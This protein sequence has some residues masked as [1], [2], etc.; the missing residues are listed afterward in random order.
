[1]WGSQLNKGFVS[2]VRPFWNPLWLS[3]SGVEIRLPDFVVPQAPMWHHQP[4]SFGKILAGGFSPPHRYRHSHRRPTRRHHPSQRFI[5]VPEASPANTSNSRHSP[6]TKQ[7]SAAQNTGKRVEKTS[8]AYVLAFI[9]KHTRSSR[10]PARTHPPTSRSRLCITPRH[11]F[12][13]RATPA[14]LAS[15]CC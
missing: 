12:S 1:M 13:R 15:I 14:F 11:Y 5:E 8:N 7:A 10:P 4:R 9:Y 3:R 2:P 6:H